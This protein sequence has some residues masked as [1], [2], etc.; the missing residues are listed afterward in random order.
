M[1]YI[2]QTL[3]AELLLYLN[4]FVMR[5]LVQCAVPVMDSFNPISLYEVTFSKGHE[6]R[7]VL[8]PN[9]KTTQLVC[10]L[11]RY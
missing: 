2:L 9:P 6:E 3:T 4:N 10:F 1:L 7:P 11:P 5:R 8:M